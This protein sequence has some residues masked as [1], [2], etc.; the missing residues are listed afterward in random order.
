MKVIRFASLM[1][2]LLIELLP[3]LLPTEHLERTFVLPL[4]DST[5]YPKEVSKHV[6]PG[7]N[8]RISSTRCSSHSMKAG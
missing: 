6:T 4:S 5:P 7:G 1:Q 8:V 2:C 3:E